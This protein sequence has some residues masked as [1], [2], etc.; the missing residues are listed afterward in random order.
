MS[1]GLEDHVRR[2]WLDIDGR[3]IFEA[4]AMKPGKPVGLACVGSAVLLGLPGNSF[5]ALV[6]FLV[7][8]RE[9]IAR[10]RGRAS[11]RD[12]LPARAGF[13]LDRRPGR[14]EFFPARVLGFDPDGTPVI[15]LLGKG[16]SA[17]L[18]PLVA[19]DGLGRIECDR[20]QVSVGDAV[21]F[22]PFEA[23]LRL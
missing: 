16:G 15:D 12:D 20:V 14:T 21:G 11:P 17:R 6:A 19:A 8:G 22:L 1:S 23:A 4:V 13:A 2:A 10:L 18:A 9:V 5:A 3:I 7:V